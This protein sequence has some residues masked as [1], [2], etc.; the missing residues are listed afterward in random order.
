MPKVVSNGAKM[1][2][3]KNGIK[4]F[5]SSLWFI[6][7][8]IFLI[9]SSIFLL[10]NNKFHVYDEFFYVI[11]LNKGIGNF[12]NYHMFSNPVA[13]AVWSTISLIGIKI[14]AFRALQITSSIFAALGATA[15]VDIGMF[16]GLSLTNSFLFSLPITFCNGFIRYGTCAYPDSLALGVG[17]VAVNMLIKSVYYFRRNSNQLKPWFITGLLFGLASLMHLSSAVLFPILLFGV[18]LMIIHVN[19]KLSRKILILFFIFGGIFLTLGLTYI[20]FLPLCIKFFPLQVA[21]YKPVGEFGRGLI[22]TAV[23]KNSAWSPGLRD[24]LVD[25][26][27]HGA[28]FIPGV[29]S[30][31]MILDSIFDI[32]RI[33]AVFLFLWFAIKAFHNR[34]KDRELFAWILTFASTAIFDFFVLLCT[35]FSNTRQYA[36]VS[37]TVAGPLLVAILVILFREKVV[38]KIHVIIFFSCILFYAVFG[39]EG[40]VDITTYKGAPF[41]K[42]YQNC[43]VLRPK[44]AGPFFSTDNSIDPGCFWVQ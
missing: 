27:T 2:S 24:L 43:D 20:I 23:G 21:L 16:W 28:I 32:P 19:K 4:V 1:Q 29:H 26:K 7:L 41:T 12:H 39:I 31:N 38:S 3:F 42:I 22:L 36:L 18:L 33:L 37:L 40:I 6:R 8:S 15:L 44:Y 10:I 11:N 25:F 9:F 34:S 14:S 13:H 35:G 5:V 30:K 17:L